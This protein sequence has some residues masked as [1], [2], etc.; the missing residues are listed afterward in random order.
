MAIAAQNTG[1]DSKELVRTKV[2]LEKEGKSHIAIA[3]EV[4]D[5]FARRIPSRAVAVGLAV[6]ALS[7]L[8]DMEEV[9][10][11]DALGLEYLETIDAAAGAAVAPELPEIGL[12]DYIRIGKSLMAKGV[13]PSPDDFEPREIFD[14][15]HRAERARPSSAEVSEQAAAGAFAAPASAT[16]G[17]YS[18]RQPTREGETGFLA[19]APS[20]AQTAG[21]ATLRAEPS[22]LN[23]GQAASYAAQASHQASRIQP[24]TP[25]KEPGGESVDAPEPRGAR[26]DAR[27]DTGHS[28]HPAP[29]SADAHGPA[30]TFRSTAEA[31]TELGAKPKSFSLVAPGAIGSSSNRPHASANAGSAEPH[32]SV[33]REGGAPHG[34][35][36]K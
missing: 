8:T 30:R 12:N 22:E 27:T 13:L 25:A 20:M 18:S 6:T 9:A 11:L 15:V 26:A 34:S 23:P 4:V 16:M 35:K 31:S 2:R 33:S 7:R 28:F 10:R 14:R 21:A 24:I 5:G 3:A 1:L 36:P 19:E 32:A 17:E 29:G